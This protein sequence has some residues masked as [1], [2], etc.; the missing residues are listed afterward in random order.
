MDREI[1]TIMV[2]L[3]VVYYLQFRSA[4]TITFIEPELLRINKLGD[5]E[6]VPILLDLYGVA[7]FTSCRFREA[8]RMA[9]KALAIAER[10]GD[11]GP[12][13]TLGP[14]LS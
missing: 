5:A 4:E 9:D 12:W 10:L 3:A 6:Q 11:A 7:L 8:K 14:A 13:R 1:A 2:D